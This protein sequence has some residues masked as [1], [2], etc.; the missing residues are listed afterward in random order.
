MQIG[1]VT[2]PFGPRPIKLAHVKQ[3]LDV[4]SHHNELVVGKWKVFREVAEARQL[5][6]LQD[7]AVAVLNALLSFYPGGELKAGDRLVVFPSNAQLSARAHGIAGTT[8]RRHL[9]ALVEAGL[10]IR[11]DSPNGKRYAHR[12]GD[13]QIGQAFGFDL[14]PLLFRSAELAAMAQEVA[15]ERQAFR[16][17]REAL[18]ICRR[19][20]RKLIS[21]AMEEE[22]DGDWVAF[23]ERY[24]SIVSSLCRSPCRQQVEDTLAEMELLRDE[25]INQLE[26]HLKSRKTATNDVQ[27]GRHIQE[28]K[29]ESD[30][31][32]EP[33]SEKEQGAPVEP[34]KR[35]DAELMKVIPLGVIVRACP[36]ITDYGPAGTISSWR[37]LMGAAVTVRSILGVSPSA[38]QDACEAMG[39]E[40]AAATIA[41]ILERAEHINSAGGYLRA[42]TARSLRGEF[43]L[44]PALLA[45]CRRGAC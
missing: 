45:L 36:K 26:I 19:D 21:A 17:A 12:D 14:A 11:R 5:L 30:T 20:V 3:Q 38:Y 29:T 18:T 4:A 43:S 9:A 25:V 42:L 24:L 27:N 6:D 10:L 13:G 34:R 39:P 44:G 33:C 16:R 22:A 37:E 40:N 32:F 7:R 2:T 15:R 41:C 28:S 8:L 23:E 1:N 31:E 35:R